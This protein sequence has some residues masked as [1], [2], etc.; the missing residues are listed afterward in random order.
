MPLDVPAGA[1]VG[2]DAVPDSAGSNLYTA[3]PTLRR[4][5]ALYLPR[6]VLDHLE[7]H[8]VRLGA[9][10]GGA[11][12]ELAAMADRNPPVLRA[13]T[14]TGADRARI[15]KHP[16]YLEMERLA[17]GEYGLAAMSHRGGVLG[18]PGQDAAR[19]EIRC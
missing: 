16:A 6:D 7:P 19:G 14:R 12:D 17:F 1:P 13:R 10:A 11:L 3:D 9:L 8:L 5:A 18:W 2:Q 15:E 4:V